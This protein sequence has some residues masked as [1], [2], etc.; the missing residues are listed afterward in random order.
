MT[1]QART[2]QYLT[3]RG[4]L[5][6]A[7]EARKSFPAKGKSACKACG[8]VP[9]VSVSVDLWNIFD[10]VALKPI[11]GDGSFSYGGTVFVQT[12]SRA[13]HSTRRNKIL[14]S[15]EAKL[16][17]LSGA[18]ILLQSW[19]QDG[20]TRRWSAKDEFITL[21]DFRSALHYP[22]TVAELVE[23][24][25]KAK[26]PDFPKGS[27]LPLGD[28]FDDDLPPSPPKRKYAMI[29]DEEIPF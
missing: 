22:N 8:H 5:V 14:S 6:G 2:R 17:L 21:A 15:M 13:N 29:P 28:E 3:D 24:K 9:L 4:Y 20:D 7:C 11:S 16:V 10:L 25:R 27:T 23:I 18:S 12:T 1:P 26:R 19:A